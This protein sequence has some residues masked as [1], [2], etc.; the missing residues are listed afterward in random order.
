MPQVITQNA[1]KIKDSCTK[2]CTKKYIAKINK[3]QRDAINTDYWHMNY[4]EKYVLQFLKRRD[5]QSQTQRAI[6][7]KKPVPFFIF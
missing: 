4:T 1:H 5:V 2:S 3:C 7:H 6:D